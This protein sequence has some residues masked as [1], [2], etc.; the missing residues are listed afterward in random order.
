MDYEVGGRFGF[1]RIG[2]EA[3][4]NLNSERSLAGNFGVI[5][6]IQG[7]LSNPTP[8]PA[9]V[10]LLFEASAGYGSGLFVINGDLVKIGLIQPKQEI[11]LATIKLPPGVSKELNLKTIPLSGANYPVTLIVRPTGIELKSNVAR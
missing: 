6:D 4:S 1:A 5:Y 7:T 11:V 3:I 8:S 10:E 2:Q 9:E